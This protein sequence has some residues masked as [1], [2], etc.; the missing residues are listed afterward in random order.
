MFNNKDYETRLAEWV[1]CRRAIEISKN[2]IDFAISIYDNVEQNSLQC[3]PWDKNSWPTPWE[4]IYTNKYCAF[5]KVL[6]IIYTL[7]LT[8]MFS[9]SQFF[10]L[11]CQNIEIGNIDFGLELDKKCYLYNSDNEILKKISVE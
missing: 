5:T 2:P 4:L 8:K 11:I 3:D 10:L 9:H 6:G 7:K 1:K